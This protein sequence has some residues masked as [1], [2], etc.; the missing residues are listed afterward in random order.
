MRNLTRYGAGAVAYHHGH[1][2]RIDGRVMAKHPKGIG[3]WRET[4]TVPAAT[5][6]CCK[7][8]TLSGRC[9]DQIKSE[10]NAFVRHDEPREQNSSHYFDADAWVCQVELQALIVFWRCSTK[11]HLGH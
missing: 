5:A 10:S 11:A 8:F 1:N 7:R 4:Q 6:F 9:A 2:G 3:H